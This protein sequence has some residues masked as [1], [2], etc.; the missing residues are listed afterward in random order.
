M[1]EK[2]A[3]W[4]HV[5]G[6]TRILLLT[7]NACRGGIERECRQMAEKLFADHQVGNL[8]IKH[9]SIDEVCRDSMTEPISR[10][11]RGG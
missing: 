10:E 6:E 3:V 7:S 4:A 5:G 11:T 2:Y 8:E 1:S 9:W